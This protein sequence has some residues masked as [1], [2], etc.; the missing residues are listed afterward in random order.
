MLGPVIDS[1]CHISSAW[2]EPIESLLFQMERNGI[3]NAVLIQLF[4]QFNNRELLC[5]H[6]RFPGRFAPVVMVDTTD[7]NAHETLRDL[8]DAGAM[9]VRLEANP[10]TSCVDPV[11]IWRA[12]DRLGIPVSCNGE[13]ADYLSSEFARV[14]EAFPELTIVIEHLGR[15][16]GRP[17]G[18]EREDEHFD[19]FLELARF[20]NLMLRF[21]GLGELL[22]RQSVFEGD[23]VPFLPTSRDR[24]AAAV[25]AFGPERMMWGSDYPP[26]SGREGYRNALELPQQTLSHL[27]E[28]A[29]AHLFGGTAARVYHFD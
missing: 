12:A 3:A 25:D 8:V 7:P 13:T 15:G 5:A 21:H 6:R 11:M 18:I 27:G 4:G 14:L 2:Y 10:R 19:E 9:G 23:V 29:L 20:P 26:V 24:L 1:H 28:E 16:D 22:H 17:D